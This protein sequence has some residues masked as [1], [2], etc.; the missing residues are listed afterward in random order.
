MKINISNTVP[1]KP[2]PQASS[3]DDNNAPWEHDTTRQ[4]R[5]H[6]IIDESKR[7]IIPRLANNRF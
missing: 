7:Q 3:S 4:E 5:D 2:L 6:V 1:S